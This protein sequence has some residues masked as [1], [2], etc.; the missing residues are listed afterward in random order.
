MTTFI[1]LLLG[2]TLHVKTEDS[3][4]RWMGWEGMAGQQSIRPM[5]VFHCNLSLLKINPALGKRPWSWP[6][7]AGDVD[8]LVRGW[9]PVS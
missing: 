8:A 3:F 5:S 6:S 2:K 7:F 9:P 1:L 4:R